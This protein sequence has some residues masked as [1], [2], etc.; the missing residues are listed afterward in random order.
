VGGH[1]ARSAGAILRSAT[2]VGNRYAVAQNPPMLGNDRLTDRQ[3]RFL[4]ASRVGHLATA[5]RGGVPHVIPVCYAL[6]GATVY[7]T[8]DEKPK[9]RD[10][11]LKRM[12][13]LLENPRFS[14][15]VD[16]WDEDW[17]RL[18][19]V[20]LRGAAEILDS[21]AEHDRAQTLLRER[22]P[23]YRT[24]ALADL[25]VLALRIARAMDWGNLS[26]P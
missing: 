25:P 26:P 8:I 22:Y 18:G 4:D 21:G 11:P 16:R 17:A 20:M 19:W 2:G 15:V 1:G 6:E 12:R 24:M 7:I 3:R 9:R 14:F 5:D 13:N 10:I 23:Q